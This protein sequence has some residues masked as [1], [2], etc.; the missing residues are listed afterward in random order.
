[1]QR[2]YVLL[3]REGKLMLRSNDFFA[4]MRRAGYVAPIIIISLPSLRII[5]IMGVFLFLLLERS[6]T[7][8]RRAGLPQTGQ[9]NGA[10]QEALWTQSLPLWVGCLLLIENLFIVG[11]M[12]PLRYPVA[13]RATR[14]GYVL[15]QR[16]A[17]PAT[18]LE[19]C[20]EAGILLLFVLPM[21]SVCIPSTL[22]ASATASGAILCQL[23]L[24]RRAFDRYLRVEEESEI[25]ATLASSELPIVRTFRSYLP[26]ENVPAF[27]WRRWCGQEIYL[28]AGFLKTAPTSIVQ[29]L[30][31]HEQ[32]HVALG[33]TQLLFLLRCFR[34]IV[35][36]SGLLVL[37]VFSTTLGQASGPAVVPWLLAFVG[38]LLAPDIVKL[39]FQGVWEQRAD[40]WAA[41]RL[42]QGAIYTARLYVIS[43][44]QGK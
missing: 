24:R 33:H 28:D 39:L 34:Y 29:T 7:L 43:R 23:C 16:S 41:V 32:G 44:S 27:A 31:M 10:Q 38:G 4:V 12:L 36:I 42:G 11:E 17:S 13:L 9:A 40:R 15:I 1:M 35:V 26:Q 21:L 25:V 22:I 19:Y 5:V 2:M 18:W 3:E 14:Q 37:S 20:L 30:F 6:T 8:S